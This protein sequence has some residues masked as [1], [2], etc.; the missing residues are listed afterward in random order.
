MCVG[1]GFSMFW[2][3]A[4]G[5]EKGCLGMLHYTDVWLLDLSQGMVVCELLCSVLV[6][7]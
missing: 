7:R 1:S 3:G 6:M 4:L 5:A 2:E